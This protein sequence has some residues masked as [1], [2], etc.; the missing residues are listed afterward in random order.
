MARIRTVKPELFR[1]E[2]LFEAE[3][4]SKLPL[5]LAYIGLFTA[6]DREGRFKWKPRAL[7]L[8]VLPYDQIDFSRVL[9]ALVTHGFIVKYQNE[10]DEFGCIPTWSQHQVINNRES[11]SLLPSP[12]ES[13]ACTSEPRVVDASV[14]P[15]VQTQGEGKGRE[16]EGKRKGKK[17][18]A[19]A[20]RPEDVSQQVWDDWVALRKRKGTTISETAVDGAREEAA[21]IG[22]TLQQFLVEWCT[23]GSQG[24]KAE[25]IKPEQKQSLSRT[26]QT[27]QSVMSGLTRGL[28]GGGNHVKLLG[29]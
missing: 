27:N 14:T 26:G 6:C 17:E 22:W 15:L 5:R 13:T 4:Q 8:D 25:W 9:D 16:E 11:T 24:L 20:P 1:H 21:K 2:A 28:V 10:G 18:S 19:V 3:Q 29:N 12:E 23:R 7:K